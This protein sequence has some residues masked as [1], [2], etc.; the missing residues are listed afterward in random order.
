MLFSITPRTKSIACIAHIARCLMHKL[1]QKLSQSLDWKLNK[2][3][4]IKP[5]RFDCCCG[6]HVRSH[7]TLTRAR[8]KHTSENKT[9]N[10]THGTSYSVMGPLSKS[11]V[12]I[13]VIHTWNRVS[14]GPLPDHV[15]RDT[16]REPNPTHRSTKSGV[17]LI[18]TQSFNSLPSLTSITN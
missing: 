7:E 5:L 11:I 17:R 6:Q 10:T 8:H 18:D 14:R 12:H 2:H 16:G 4:H 13:L 3:V 15:T 9:K 1:T